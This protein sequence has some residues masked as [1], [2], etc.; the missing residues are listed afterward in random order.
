MS[1]CSNLSSTDRWKKRRKKKD[2]DKES[3]KKKRRKTDVSGGIVEHSSGY[4]KSRAPRTYYSHTYIHTKTPNMKAQQETHIVMN[5]S[6]DE[7]FHWLRT[8]YYSV[9]LA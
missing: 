6:R 4:R 3:W 1:H 8:H 5:K 9:H 2:K 7:N